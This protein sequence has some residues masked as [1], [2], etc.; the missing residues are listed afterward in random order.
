MQN[1]SPGTFLDAG[2][3]HSSRR[4]GIAMKTYI[5]RALILSTTTLLTHPAIA[6]QFTQVNLVTDDKTAHS[7]VIED[8]SLKN[9]WGVS[10][11]GST[12]FWISDNGAGVSTLYSV[13]PTTDVPA[14]IGLT[15]SLQGD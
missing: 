10:F 7:A 5:Q 12:P 11:G 3:S 1:R 13:N 6:Q 15:V 8:P 4:T 2:A 9:A 14:K